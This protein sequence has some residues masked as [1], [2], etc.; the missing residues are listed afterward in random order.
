MTSA[1]YMIRGQS[2]VSVVLSRVIGA[3]LCRPN[4]PV[5][6]RLNEAKRYDGWVMVC[7]AVMLR[8]SLR[9]SDRKG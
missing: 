6:W 9:C 1:V 7:P 4:A 8:A 2:C 5:Q 3:V